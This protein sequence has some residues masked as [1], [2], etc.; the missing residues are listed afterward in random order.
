MVVAIMCVEDIFFYYYVY[1][2]CSLLTQTFGCRRM[3]VQALGGRFNWVFDPEIYDTQL[4][5][6]ISM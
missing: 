5:I 3:N 1:I 4:L 6:R 2:R